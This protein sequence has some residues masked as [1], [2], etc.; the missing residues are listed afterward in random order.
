MGH[1]NRLFRLPGPLADELAAYCDVT[2]ERPA[3]VL[4]DALSLFLDEQG[5]R[6]DLDMPAPSAASG[7]PA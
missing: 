3:D 2:N 4:A 5:E 7:A 6:I 1:P